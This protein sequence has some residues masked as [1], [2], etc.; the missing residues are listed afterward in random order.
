MQLSLCLCLQHILPFHGTTSD[1]NDDSGSIHGRLSPR[2]SVS[3]TEDD[4]SN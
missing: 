2:V 1:D 4:L 3:V